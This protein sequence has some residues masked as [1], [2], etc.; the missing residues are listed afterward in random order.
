MSR[1]PRPA[2][3]GGVPARRAVIRWAWRL[4]RR[5]WRQQVLVCGL[6]TVAVAA[7]I[8]FA[9]AAYNVAPVAGDAEFGTANHYFVF[10]DLDPAKLEAT[11]TAAQ[12]WFGTIDVV[13][14]RAVPL[15]GSV[16]DFDYRT[17]DPDGPFGDPLLALRDGR[18][19]AATDEVAVTEGIG[20]TLDLAIGDTLSADR[21][22]RTVVG[23]VEN[24]SDLGD[25]FALL[26]P[27]ALPSSYSVNLFVDAP[28]ERVD[29]FRPPGSTHRVV[30]SRAD[31]AEDV[32]AAVSVLVIA[33][34]ALFLVALVSS[35]SF[36][37]MAQRRQ[38]QL[39]MLSAVGATEQHLRLVVLANG[40]VIGAVAA[41]LGATIGV[42]GWILLAPRLEPAVGHRIDGLDVP[43]WLVVVGMVL[44]VV[45]A[46][47]AAWWPARTTAR[48]STVQALSGRPPQ[49][50]PVHRS[51]A[52]AALFIAGGVVCLAVSKDVSD[53]SAVHWTNVLLV[54]AGTIATIIGVLLVSP[55]AIRALARSAS[56]LPVSA[57]L[58]LRDLARY[59]A[60]SGA[61]LAAISLV[62]GI[63]AAIVIMATAAEDAAAAGNLSDRQV[64]IR[65]ADKDGPFAPT[66]ADLDDMEAAV[67][68]I[69]Q[70]LDDPTVLRIDVAIDPDAEPIP[71]LEGRPAI[72]LAERVED[73]WRDLTPLYVATPEL[74]ARHGVD[75]GATP[76]GFYTN[77][78]GEVH[79]L[80]IGR[81]DRTEPELLE[82]A[83][84]LPA[85][86]TSLPGSFVT[87]EEL[88]R[89]GWEAVP[90]GRWLIETGEALSGDQLEAVRELAAGSGLMIESRD[91][92]EGLTRLRTVATAIGMALALGV[93][94]MTVGL[95]RSETAADLRTLTATGASSSTRRTLTATTA[96]GL[97][98]VGAMLGTAGAYVVFTAGH[99]GDL[100]DL[101][102]IPVTQLAAIA[103]GTPLVAS[104][105]G[106]LLAGREP[107]VLARQP[108]E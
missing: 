76:S 47:G 86:Y 66:S 49:P 99:A 90:S 63:P 95:I 64:L 15:P 77:E 67:D 36:I 57:R 108:I 69:A 52:L 85:S 71:D 92:Q 2:D 48:V 19:A 46:T 81:N 26:A 30:S 93:L 22:D 88:A 4:F 21:V 3:N 31:I 60:R 97:A 38:R 79:L 61:A 18:Y 44:A 42:V 72:S 59:Q 103:I 25:D 39:G 16:D 40:A 70:A 11:I 20:E 32:L 17:Q 54:V 51:V 68:R 96:G 78:T 27:T 75:A 33:A 84:L 107:P 24:P 43:W 7:A 23:F 34:V 28:S 5:E 50:T 101:T 80:D 65:P 104:I 89:R 83:F 6:L 87:T 45:A 1:S 56:R 100:D 74:L 62:L 73:G 37:V 91:R 82:G 53:D 10:E 55:V 29:E 98:L 35:A 106:W 105:A 14:H 12:E 8:G 102:P 94:A 58:P 9:A 13:G 41:V